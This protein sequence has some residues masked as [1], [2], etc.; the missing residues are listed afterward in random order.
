MMLAKETNISI[1]VKGLAVW[2]VVVSTPGSLYKIEAFSSP[3]LIKTRPI[4]GG[5]SP[6]SFTYNVPL[7]SSP[8]TAADT[9]PPAKSSVLPKKMAINGASPQQSKFPSRF[10]INVTNMMNRVRQLSNIASFLCVLDCTIL[11]IITVALPLLGVLNLGAAQMEALHE[12]GHSLALFF[13]LPV[14]SLTT[15]LNYRSHRKP[16]IA[17]MAVMGLLLVGIANS[18][19][20]L[21]A[22]SSTPQWI[23]HSLHMIQ[24]CGPWH[25]LVN[26]SGCALLLGSNY[27]SQRQGCAHHNHGSSCSHEHDHGH[28]DHD[29]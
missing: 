1:L 6:R 8:E 15:V 24:H 2:V 27:L 26:I 16:W 21:A 17:S 7:F 5:S 11:P 28:G 23:S 18:H 4:I 9:T 29:H 19:F 22:S 10:S 12:L 25:R 13:V 14:G 3:S 20:H